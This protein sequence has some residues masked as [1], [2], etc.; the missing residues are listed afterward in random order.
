MFLGCLCI[1]LC[2][3]VSVLASRM[4]LTQ[5]LEK[6]WIYCHQTFSIVAFWDEDKCFKF[7]GHITLSKFKVTVG[8]SMLEK[9]LLALL[10]RYLE[11]YWTEFHQTFSVSEFWDK[12]E[13]INFGGQR[14]SRPKAEN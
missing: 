1:C 5:C 9:A 7:W 14:S 3:F 11:N 2:I 13:R 10:T 4:L 12:D 8:S 6:Y